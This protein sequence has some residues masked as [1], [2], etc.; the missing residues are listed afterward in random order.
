MST[1]VFAVNDDWD[2]GARNPPPAS[3]PASHAESIGAVGVAGAVFTAKVVTLGTNG[4]ALLFVGVTGVD[5]CN[6]VWW[7]PPHSRQR[8]LDAQVTAL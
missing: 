1:S 6:E 8:I 5:P 7:T 2:D 4:V 3:M